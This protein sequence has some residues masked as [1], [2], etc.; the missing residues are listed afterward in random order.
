MIS[1]YYN[2]LSIGIIAIGFVLNISKKLPISKVFL[3]FPF[4]SHVNL[5]SYLGRRTTLIKSIEKLIVDRA[6]DF[7]NFN[8]RYYDSLCI[9]INSLQYLHSMQYITLINGN[10]E[11]LKPLEYRSKMGVRAERINKAADNISHL[12]SLDVENLYL[13]LRIEL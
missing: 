2:N 1:N 13:N 7:C 6:S 8:K 10:L 9:T 12:L 5:L 3:I 4:I 11:L